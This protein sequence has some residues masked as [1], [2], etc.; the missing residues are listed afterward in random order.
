[1][2][3]TQE[4]KADAAPAPGV[5][6]RGADALVLLLLLGATFL[7]YLPVWRAGFI[8][9][10]DGH[11]TRTDLRPLHGLWRIW[12]EPGATQQYYPFLHTAFW[13]EHRL[14]GDAALGYHLVNVSLHAL[15]AWLLYRVL[16]RLS[17]PGAL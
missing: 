15:V 3:R 13:V 1:M 4:A 6:R 2:T 9:D 17:L 7:A 16:R 11:V 12:F 8:W 10:D 5:S 14:W